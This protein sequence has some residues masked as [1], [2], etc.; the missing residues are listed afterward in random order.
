MIRYKACL[1]NCGDRGRTRAESY[2]TVD[3]VDIAACADPIETTRESFAQ[4]FVVANSYG[5]FRAV[6]VIFLW[7]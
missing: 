5:D 4:D 6:R 1:I 7:I 3:N 2:Q